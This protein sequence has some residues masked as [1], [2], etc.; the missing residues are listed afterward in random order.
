MVRILLVSLLLAA[1]LAAPVSGQPS[2]AE[3]AWKPLLTHGGLDFSYL[4][5]RDA[6]GEH[7]TGNGVVLRLQNANDYAVRYRFQMIFRAE[8]EERIEPVE[9]R[10]GPNEGRTG[11]A[12]GLFWIPFPDGRPVAEVGLRGYRVE[13]E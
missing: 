12:D 13:R 6:S 2:R 1:G 5:Y 3:K 4:F 9:G 11:S 8:G 7:E 10:L